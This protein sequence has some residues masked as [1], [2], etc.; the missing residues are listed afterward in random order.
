[1][2]DRPGNRFSHYWP[3]IVM[4]AFAL[5]FILLLVQKASPSLLS[6]PLAFGLALVFPLVLMML[7]TIT[8]W[9]LIALISARLR[10]REPG[11]RAQG[12]V[13]FTL[14][15]L[16]PLLIYLL[17]APMLPDR[18]PTGSYLSDF[19]HTAWLDENSTR[20]MQGDITSRQKMLADAVSRLPGHNREEVIALLGPPLDTRFLK[21]NDSDLLYPLGPQRD[22]F[23]GMDMEFLRVA[24]DASDTV[25]GYEIVTD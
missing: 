14:A 23:W 22:T 9:S 17:A 5:Y 2:D 7:A 21:K 25:T 4:S 10:R 1:M 13:R 3:H 11:P 24:F 6:E 16:I 20:Y 19:D 15:G 18:L 12:A 8:V